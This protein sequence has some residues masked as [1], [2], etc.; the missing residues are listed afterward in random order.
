MRE[1]LEAM[2]EQ[3]FKRI[4]VVNGHGGNMPAQGLTGEVMADHPGIQ[5][6]FHNWW[7]APRT[8]AEVESIDPIAGHASWAENF[9]WTRLA[10][11]TMPDEEKPMSDLQRLRRSDPAS[12][13]RYLKD[14][15]LLVQWI[16]TYDISVDLL[17]SIF[18]A[19]GA[20][21]ATT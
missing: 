5:I 18:K 9:P 2:V 20:N 15:G 12:L 4:V 17:A 21:T 3:G 19:L 11:V 8:W 10:N 16:Q 6:K 14:D 1:L 7:N 13:R